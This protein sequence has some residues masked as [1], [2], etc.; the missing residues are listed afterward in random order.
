MEEKKKIVAIVGAGAAGC[1]AAINLRRFCPWAEV[2]VYEGLHKP[3]AKVALT[4]GG[5]CNLTNSF[6]GLKS[7]EEAYP[8]GGRL[9]KRLLKEY[10]HQDVC[11][12]F[13]REG[14]QLVTQA[15]GCV[16]PRS[17]DA[18][19]IVDTLTRLM[20]HT[21]V[22]LKTGHRVRLIERC[23]EE[24]TGQGKGTFKI[25]FA[26][27]VS[28]VCFADVVIVTTGGS[29]K[30]SGL[31]LLHPLG[32]SIAEPVPSLFSVCVRDNAIT[33]LAGTVVDEVTVSLPGTRHRAAGPLLVTHWGLS[34]PAILKL[35]SYAARTLHEAGYK[36]K[37]SVNWFGHKNEEEVMRHIVEMAVA[38]AQKK[39]STAHPRHINLRLW[40][41]LLRESG[42]NHEQRWGELS[43][44][45]HRQLVSTLTNNVYAIEGKNRFKDEFVTCGGVALT[46]INPATLESRR[47]PGLYFAGEVTDLDAITGGFNLQAAWTMGY[48][49]AR[50]AGSAP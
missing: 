9:M 16:F 34:G 23:S 27:D 43:L 10:G 46:E 38:N 22:T 14:V 5:R 42:L 40:L 30:S 2:T 21:G 20:R 3:L 11:R 19:E 47:H 18:M 31:H 6:G 33:E 7:V 26:D 39:L 15:D 8:R 24:E 49:A 12:W 41:H 28:E 4:G 13:E 48:V 36:A 29:P 35:S 32:H 17:Q 37:V 1:F 44:K 45:S 50:S 25:S